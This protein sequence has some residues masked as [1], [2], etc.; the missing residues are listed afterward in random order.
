LETVPLDPEL[1]PGEDVPGDEAPVP[2]ELPLLLEPCC[3]LPAEVLPGT[4][5]PGTVVFEVELP[6]PPGDDD[7][8]EL[9]PLEDEPADEELEPEVLCPDELRVVR[10]VVFFFASAPPGNA[11]V[12][13]V[14]ASPA[15][16]PSAERRVNTR[17]RW[18]SRCD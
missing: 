8:L 11:I 17:G 13:A 12:T 4:V 9:V 18:S 6:L 7:P 10:R 5:V 3:E 16:R 2:L 15:N 1:D 14:A